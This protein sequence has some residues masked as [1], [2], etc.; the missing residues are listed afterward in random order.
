MNNT[1][2]LDEF[3]N[4][5]ILHTKEDLKKRKAG[6]LASQ[7]LDFITP[8]VKENVTTVELDKLCHDFILNKGAVPAPLNYKGFQNLYV[9]L[10]IMLYVVYQVIKL[11]KLAI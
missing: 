6:I 3:N 1:V 5:V 7:V 9:P 8:Y 10:S 11:S 2:I 4:P